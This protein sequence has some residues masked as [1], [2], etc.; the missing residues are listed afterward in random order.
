MYKVV[1]LSLLLNTFVNAQFLDEKNKPLP[2]LVVENFIDDD[3]SDFL[4][5][6]VEDSLNLRKTVKRDILGRK[7][8]DSL[9]YLSSTKEEKIKVVIS[10]IREYVPLSKEV[11]GRYEVGYGNEKKIWLNGKPLEEDAYL[12]DYEVLRKEMKAERMYKTPEIRY[13]SAS[14]IQGLLDGPNKVS[15]SLYKEPQIFS[16][17]TVVGS[18]VY[19]RDSLIR[20]QSQIQTYAFG[21][22]YKGS[23]IGIYFTET[24]CPN[25]DYV[26]RQYYTVGRACPHGTRTHPTGVVRVLQSTAPQA[27]IYGFDQVNLPVNPL[28]AYNPPL[29]IGSHS[30]GFLNDSSYSITD[31]DFDNYIYETGVIEFVAAGNKIYDQDNFYVASP[32]KSVNSITVGAVEPDT[33]KNASYTRWKN[34]TL[35]NQKPEIP[36]FSHFY[37]KGDS[38]FSKYEDDSWHIYNGLFDGTSAST[39]YTA[40]MA[41]DVLSQHPFFK[42][43]PEMFKALML[44]GSTISVE[45][46]SPKDLDNYILIKKIPQYFRMGWNTRSAFWRG[47]NNSF[48]N[49]DSTISFMES[50]IVS[51][52]RYRI[53]ISWLSQGEYIKENNLLPQDLDLFV[54]QENSLVAQ[55]NSANNPFEIVDFTAQNSSDLKIVIKRVRNSGFDNVILGYNFLIFN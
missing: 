30:W 13:V 43:H 44:A 54:Y 39:P 34:S 52:K 38:S 18:R 17:D 47:N 2:P 41:A 42:T 19:Y 10:E 55:S 20:I 4:K 45:N 3:V 21:N 37:F 33:Y 31:R 14:E 5:K 8:R 22:G 11:F 25:M 15:I 32:G 26:N 40:A 35:K 50:G 16:N 28:D 12:Q 46:A 24:G 6:K 23:G 49:S 51:G 48:F 27:M 1:L 36:N 53:A 9:T 7:L 29:Y